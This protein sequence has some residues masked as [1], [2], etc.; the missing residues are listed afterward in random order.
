MVNWTESR[1]GERSI[2]TTDYRGYALEVTA[3]A[4]GSGGH[5][6]ATVCR[7]APGGGRERDSKPHWGQSA[8]EALERACRAAL[9]Q[10]D[11][12]S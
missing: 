5:F 3:I 6:A 11:A 4:V 12:D 7:I 2:R 10:V 1:E 8:D 9:Q